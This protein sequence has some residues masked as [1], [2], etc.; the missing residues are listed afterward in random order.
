MFWERIWT[1][2]KRDVK[3]MSRIDQEEQEKTDAFG[4]P[5]RLFS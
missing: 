3:T 4:D 1:P 2:A 5:Q